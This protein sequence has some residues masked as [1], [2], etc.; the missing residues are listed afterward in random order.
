MQINLFIRIN[1]HCSYFLPQQPFSLTVCGNPLSYKKGISNNTKSCYA[2]TVAHFNWLACY[3]ISAYSEGEKQG[4]ADRC[5]AEDI[6]WALWQGASQIAPSHTFLYNPFPWWAE[7]GDSFQGQ[8][9]S[10]ERPHEPKTAVSLHASSS[11]TGHCKLHSGDEKS[12]E[13]CVSEA[14]P[15][16]ERMTKKRASGGGTRRAF[17]T[18]PACCHP[19]A[20]TTLFQEVSP[21]LIGSLWLWSEEN[22]KIEINYFLPL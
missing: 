6:G 10:K 3:R 18:Y 15:G 9:I 5:Y 1:I 4:T 21:T 8:N 22:G 19:Q 7:P 12:G 14:P 2:F 20:H 11:C 16:L 17:P 13:K